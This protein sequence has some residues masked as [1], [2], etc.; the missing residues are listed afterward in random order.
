MGEAARQ[1]I[2]AILGESVGN[3]KAV[4]YCSSG[5]CNSN[6]FL[7]YPAGSAGSS[8]AHDF[9][10]GKIVARDGLKAGGG[11]LG[12]DF[13]WV[14]AAALD[15]YP[16]FHAPF[17]TSLTIGPWRRIWRFERDGGVEYNNPLPFRY[18]DLLKS[19]MLVSEW[20]RCGKAD[21]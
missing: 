20:I 1:E 4:E 14:V 6:L 18:G 7:K 11:P 3:R 15:L 2:L 21:L 17:A 10:G 13:G 19:G 16:A 12:V 8:G 5:C 9:G